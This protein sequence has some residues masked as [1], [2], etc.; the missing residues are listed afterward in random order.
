MGQSSFTAKVWSTE[1]LSTG[2]GRIHVPG[3]TQE[4]TEEGEH[5]GNHLFAVLALKL[6]MK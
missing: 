1:V 4:C 2:E 6:E 3:S 5:E